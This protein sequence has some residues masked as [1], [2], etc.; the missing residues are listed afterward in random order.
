MYEQMVMIK[1][2]YSG[3]HERS[4]EGIDDRFD[5]DIDDDVGLIFFRTFSHIEY[6]DSY[7]LGCV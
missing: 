6:V 3:Q 1:L 4:K 2:R 5:L 7:G